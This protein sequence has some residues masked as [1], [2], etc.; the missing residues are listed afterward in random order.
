MTSAFFQRLIGL[1]L[2]LLLIASSAAAQ[3]VTAL[4]G[5]T[6]VSTEREALLEEATVLL[7]GRRIA[8]VGSSAEVEVPEGARVI[9]VSGQYVLPG[10]I[11]AHVHFFQ[12]GGLYTRPDVIDLRF[13]KPYTEEI[14]DIKAR[15]P[16]TLARYLA[17]GVTS[18]VDV[19]GP[20]WNFAVRRVADSLRK[21]PH[22]TIAGPLLSS[23]QPEELAVED[24]P[25]IEVHDPERARRLVRE[26]VERGVDL[27]KIWYI[28]RRSESPEDHLPMVRAVIDEAHA[29][30][31]P[32]AVHATG[33]E[34][35]RAAVRAGADILVHSVTDAPVDEAFIQL[36]K[37][38]DV[39]YT[40]TLMV[41]ARYGAVLSQQLD[42]LPVE[43]ELAD[44]Q[45]LA[46]LDDL[47]ALPPDSL[48][49]GVRRLMQRKPEIGPSAT[50]MQNLAFLQEAG[51]T[52]AAGT[53]AGNIGTLHGPSLHYELRL[54][55]RA[56]LSPQEVLRAATLG[57]AKLAGR[58]AEV[59]TVEAG[60]LADLIVLGNNP[61]DDLAHLTN[62]RL[63]IKS[64]NVFRPEELIEE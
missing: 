62:L 12:S 43:R 26:Q 49:P 5:G 30:D 1:F 37:E 61:L 36:L 13:A 52:I 32:V 3:P 53:D 17:S 34:T 54:M 15:L 50:A 55:H 38:N 42:L 20:M 9:D 44:P 31:T 41:S 63:V 25:I 45:V 2:C 7:E 47:Q 6:V 28:V 4:V 19:G 59:G 33:L 39:V 10:L 46:S 18:V 27:I 29:H 23:Y 57:G 14:A 40:P 58:P 60:K 16:Q 51:V 22:V 48:P 8:A 11:D 64:G 24:P 56:G 35:A 21:A